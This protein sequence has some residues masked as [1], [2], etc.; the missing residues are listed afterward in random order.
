MSSS[1]SGAVEPGVPSVPSVRSSDNRTE[2]RTEVDLEALS[3]FFAA[4]LHREGISSQ[5][6]ASLTLLDPSEIAH[7]KQQYLDGDGSATDVLSFPMDGAICPEESAGGPSTWMVGD[8]LLCPQVAATQAP[9]HA[10]NLEDELALLVIHG[11]LHLL[12]WD[13]AEK[14]ER[15]LMWQRE[16]ELFEALRGAPE[17]DPWSEEDYNSALGNSTV[18]E[19]GAP[20]P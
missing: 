20:K 4:A 13:H 6:E 2:D 8:L 5:A 19:Q 15:N 1:S 9:E 14:E 18:P 7:L 16:R 17:R 11:T 3:E 10:G 12:G